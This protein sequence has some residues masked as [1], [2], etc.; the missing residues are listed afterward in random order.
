MR[1]LAR[2]LLVLGVV[3][4]FVLVSVGIG[5][6]LAANGD[7]RGAIDD[8]VAAEARGDARTV[9][10]LVR[11][12]EGGCGQ[13]VAQLRRSGTVRVLRIDPSTRFALGAVSA[14][15][16]VAWKAAGPAV[17]QCVEVRRRGDVVSGLESELLSVTAPISIEKGC[18]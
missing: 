4:V 7:E 14:T 13:L 6:V 10:R 11:R 18:R 5:R 8:L 3:V 17:A 1:L 12:C 15:T 9:A 16:R 2:A